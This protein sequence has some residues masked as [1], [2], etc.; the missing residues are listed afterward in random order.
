MNFL[1]NLC[2]RSKICAL[3]GGKSLVVQEIQSYFC[4]WF[5]DYRAAAEGER[6][7]EA[8]CVCVC[9]YIV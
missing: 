9:V 6:E 2:I 7:T 3:L 8:V 1:L 4:V 5:L